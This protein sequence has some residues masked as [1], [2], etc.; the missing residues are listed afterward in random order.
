MFEGKHIVARKWKPSIPSS[1]ATCE[2]SVGSIKCS[3]S[4]DGVQMLGKVEEKKGGRETDQERKKARMKDVEW[5][6]EVNLT[7]REAQRFH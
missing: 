7:D 4:H 5:K 2:S 1:C 3:K 6:T